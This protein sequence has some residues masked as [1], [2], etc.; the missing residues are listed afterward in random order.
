VRITIPTQ[1]VLEVLLRQPI[2]RWYGLE[3]RRVTGLKGG[4]LYPIVARFEQ[5]GWLDS[6]WEEP[7]LHEGSGRPR[8]R[9]YWLTEK[10]AQEAAAVLAGRPARL[11]E[12]RSVRGLA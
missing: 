11:T 10:G 5:L 9:Y 7:E 3:L 8:R 1:L 12:L 4:T 6:A 2:H